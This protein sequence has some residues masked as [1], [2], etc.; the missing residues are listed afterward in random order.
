M[1]EDIRDY[2]IKTIVDDLVDMWKV[3]RRLH[4][5]YSLFKMWHLW[6][7]MSEG[8]WSHFLVVSDSTIE[9]FELYLRTGETMLTPPRE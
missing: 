8:Y 6:V 2:G 1:R 7:E 4:L 9:K 3:R 5:H